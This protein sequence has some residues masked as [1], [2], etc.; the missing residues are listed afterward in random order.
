MEFYQP[1]V[2]K[3]PKWLVILAWIAA[4]SGRGSAGRALLLTYSETGSIGIRLKDGKDI[5]ITVTDQMGSTALKGFEKI[6]KTLKDSGIKEIER[7]REIR[8]MVM[9][10]M[11]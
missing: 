7:I 5:F 3:T 10:I 11:R 4:L 1:V 9:E 2:F 6:I 8:S